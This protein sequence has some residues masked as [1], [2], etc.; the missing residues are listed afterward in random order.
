V[1]AAGTARSFGSTGN[2]LLAR[3]IVDIARTPAGRGYWLLA[4]DG[5]VFAYGD[6]HFYGSTGN[7][8]LVRPAVQMASTRSGH[9]YWFVASDGGVFA[10]GDA[11]FYGS[12]GGRFLAAPVVGIL[13]TSTGR[14]YWLVASD[15][16]VFAFGDARFR[17]SLANVHLVA[18]IVAATP[19]VTN[20]GYWLVGVDGGVFSFGDAHYLGRTRH[21]PIDIASLPDGA[22]YATVSLSGLVETFVIPP[23]P[24]LPQPFL[25]WHAGAAAAG[26]A[27]TPDSRGVWVA[28]SGRATF[29]VLASARGRYFLLQPMRW[30]R[31]RAATWWLDPTDKP[32]GAESFLAELFDYVNRVTGMQFHFGGAAT[33]TTPLPPNAVLVGW[34]DLRG[35]GVSDALGIGEPIGS[36][37]G[38]FFLQEGSRSFGWHASDTGQVAIHELGHA[39]GLA[40]NFFDLTSIMDYNDT[41]WRFGPGDL[42]G[43]RGQIACF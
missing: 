42:A 40:H 28:T 35:F 26:L 25:N 21:S 10:F 23:H 24:V 27:I 16:G 8:R 34:R 38:S 2:L 33:P 17:G 3:P 4:G 43:L 19:T 32:V 36:D 30:N 20:R 11:H 37:R 31:C 15:G 12:M 7:L 1:S 13:P 9:G 18:P 29:D 22:G 5:G 14:G 6:A 41:Q 39:M